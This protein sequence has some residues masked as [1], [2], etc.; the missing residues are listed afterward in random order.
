MTLQ[1]GMQEHWPP[2]REPLP[3]R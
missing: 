1:R 2:L 3:V